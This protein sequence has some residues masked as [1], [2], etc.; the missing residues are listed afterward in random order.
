MTSHPVTVYSRCAICVCGEQYQKTQ[1]PNFMSWVKHGHDTTFLACFTRSGLFYLKLSLKRSVR[2]RDKFHCNEPA[3]FTSA[4][5]DAEKHDESIESSESLDSG[6]ELPIKQVS[7]KSA[8]STPVNTAM[9]KNGHCVTWLGPKFRKPDLV[10]LTHHAGQYK[11]QFIARNW[12][13]ISVG[14]YGWVKSH[15]THV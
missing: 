15:I 8:T 10:C 5:D 7:M 13:H 4:P 6:D 2:S 14:S 1:L 3:S 9:T 11:E 12:A